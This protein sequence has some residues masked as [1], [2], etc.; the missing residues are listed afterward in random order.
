MLSSH[1]ESTQNYPSMKIA[2]SIADLF[3]ITFLSPSLSELPF[4]DIYTV[5]GQ[6]KGETMALPQLPLR[7]T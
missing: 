4:E 3:I 7:A 1:V 6:L 5:Q 2:F